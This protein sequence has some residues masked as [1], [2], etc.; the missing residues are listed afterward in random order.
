MSSPQKAFEKGFVR[1][2]DGQET[3]TMDGMVLT[4]SER[5]LPSILAR[6]WLARLSARGSPAG[7]ELSPQRIPTESPQGW[8][9]YQLRRQEHYVAVGYI[10]KNLMRANCSTKKSKSKSEPKKL[11]DAD[12]G[13]IYFPDFFTTAM[14]GFW[15]SGGK[16]M[17]DVEL[18]WF[19]AVGAEAK[20]AF[21]QLHLTKSGM[22]DFYSVSKAWQNWTHQVTVHAHIDITK[23]EVQMMDAFVGQLVSMVR[24][25]KIQGL[26]REIEL[27][28]GSMV[29]S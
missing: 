2:Y 5:M 3:F 19:S 26:E 20:A 7:S 6:T 28:Q 14:W 4:E 27:K 10:F 11:S 23:E 1:D 25:Q 17:S 18:T 21:G 24:K 13:C 29:Y 9:L 15:T 12:A 8:H 22:S 16:K